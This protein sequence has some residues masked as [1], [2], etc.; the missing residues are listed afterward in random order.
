MRV[1]P[2]ATHAPGYRTAVQQQRGEGSQGWRRGA[3]GG[4]SGRQQRSV[5]NHVHQCG[6][7]LGRGDVEA[8]IRG[9]ECGEQGAAICLPRTPMA[10]KGDSGYEQYRKLSRRRK[11]QNRTRSSAP[12]PPSSSSAATAAAMDAPYRASTSPTAHKSA[13]SR[14]AAASGVRAVCAAAAAWGVE[15]K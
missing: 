15:R 3:S 9:K 6:R 2:A 4:L 10:A 12:S 5:C 1:Q 14:W 7:Q 8:P 13:A 11:Y